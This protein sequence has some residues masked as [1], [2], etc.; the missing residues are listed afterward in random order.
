[1]SDCSLTRKRTGAIIV[2]LILVL[3]GGTSFAEERRMEGA[4]YNSAREAMEAY[5]DSFQKGAPS[6]ILTTFAIESYVNNADLQKM[7]ESQRF[8]DISMPLVLPVDEGNEFAFQLNCNSRYSYLSLRLYQAYRYLVG[9]PM[10][11][12]NQFFARSKGDEPIGEFVNKLHGTN[13]YANLESME[14]MEIMSPAEFGFGATSEYME[15]F[16]K[17]LTDTRH[18][19]NYDELQSLVAVLRFGGMKLYM[20]MDVVRF[21]DKW[22]NLST[23][24]NAIKHLNIGPSDGGLKFVPDF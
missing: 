18:Y 1:M 20:T 23:Q 19:L 8:Y 14:L 4:G 15:D 22:Y 24:T 21:Q 10:D 13:L 11:N 16:R 12:A 3:G 6:K 9:F 17:F 7:L 2:A 5:I